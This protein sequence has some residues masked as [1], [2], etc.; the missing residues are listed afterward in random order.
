MN[1]QTNNQRVNVFTE[2]APLREIIIG[3]C[4]NF[5]MQGIDETFRFMY[6]NRDGKFA[7]RDD[8]HKI[9]QRYLDERQEDLD[10]MQALLEGEG[11][12]V[13]RPARLDAIEAVKTP[14]FESYTTGCDSPRDMYFCI[15]NE[16]I[17]SPPT[18]RKRYFEHLLLRNVFMEYFRAGA[19]WTVAPRPSMRED[20]LDF[21][22]WKENLHDPIRQPE[23]LPESLD[24]AFDAANCLKFG[25]DVVMNV[26]TMNHELGATWLQRHLGD[27]YRVHPIRLCDTHI[28]GHLVPLA[29]GKLL[30]NEGAMHGFY[31]QLPDE[32]QRWDVIPIFDK[33]TDFDYPDDHLQMATNV[34][35]SVNVISLDERRVLIRDTAELTIKALERAGF[36]PI[37][38]RLRH[39]EL[40]GGGIHCSTVDVRRDEVMEDYFA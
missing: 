10:A 40:F 1:G 21:S 12:V 15:G 19:K 18:N 24:I 16:V 14:H 22:Y 7:D 4:V 2:W 25:R 17:E 5:N 33:S 32:L 9:D 8:P 20:S 31:Q 37:P 38:F 30:V 3:S 11:I 28:D 26:G 36:E 6:E 39:S 27:S 29:P 13:R 34:G 23:D 35:M